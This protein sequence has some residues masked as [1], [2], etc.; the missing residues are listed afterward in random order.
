MA[1]KCN[2]AKKHRGCEL[3]CMG[4][5]YIY[6]AASIPVEVVLGMTRKESAVHLGTMPW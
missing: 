1:I 6:I 3:K 5:S 4:P 2:C